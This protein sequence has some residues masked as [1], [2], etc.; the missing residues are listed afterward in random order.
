MSILRFCSSER[1]RQQK[2][3]AGKKCVSSDYSKITLLFPIPFAVE[4]NVLIPIVGL[5]ALF[6]P[7]LEMFLPTKHS[8]ELS[9]ECWY[10]RQ[11]AADS[12][13]NAKLEMT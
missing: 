13:L 8:I 1:R 10:T 12:V 9:M 5:L 4:I 7:A 2:K 11:L 3:G 6:F